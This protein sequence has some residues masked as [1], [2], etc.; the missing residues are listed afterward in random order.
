M[1]QAL[2]S[3]TLMMGFAFAAPVNLPNLPV[4]VEPNAKLAE[5]NQSFLQSTFP[6]PATRPAYVFITE[7]HKVT[8]A[9]EWRESRLATNEIE[10]LV[11][12]FPAVIRSQV[13]GIK[14]L[15]ANLMQFGGG[16]WAQFVFTTPGKGDDQRRELLVTSAGNRMLVV[17]IAGN[18]KDYSKNEAVVRNLANSIRVN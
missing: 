4:S 14:T 15:K 8:V 2:L 5:L 3:L 1:K 6:N 12:Q 9:F 18:V 13:T 16:S 17:T 11:A 10:G 7:D